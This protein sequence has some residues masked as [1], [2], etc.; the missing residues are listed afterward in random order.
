MNALRA[1]LEPGILE[2]A[3]ALAVGADPALS[4]EMVAKVA[5]ALLVEADRYDDPRARFMDPS[6]LT[7]TG[8]YFDFTR[9]EAFSWNPEVLAAGLRAARFTAQTRTPGTYTIAQHSVLASHAVSPAFQ[10]EALMH[11]AHEGLVGDIAT[12]LKILL[13]DYR[14]VEDRCELAMRRHFHLPD[15]MSREVKHVDLVMLATEKRDIMPNPDDVWDMLADVAPLKKTIKVWREERARAAFLARFHK[16]WPKHLAR[17][18]IP[19]P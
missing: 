3:Q 11:D 19:L 18:G 5:R 9:P 14:A 2:A 13:P 4:P 10:F 6:I 7:A 8:E 17:L 12:P 15:K 16:L 1:R